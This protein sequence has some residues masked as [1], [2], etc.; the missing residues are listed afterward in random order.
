M[1]VSP[2]WIDSLLQS[3]FISPVFLVAFCPANFTQWGFGGLVEIQSAIIFQS[4][5]S[6]AIA[7]IRQGR[8]VHLHNGT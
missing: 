5:Q 7:F 4:P 8:R 1:E 3:A 6:E 2:L